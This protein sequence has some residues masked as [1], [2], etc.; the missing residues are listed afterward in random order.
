MTRI[1]IVE[2]EP[3]ILRIVAVV[4]RAMGCEPLTAKDAETAEELLLGSTPDMIITD[5]RLP[6]KDGVQLTERVKSDVSMA[7]TPVLLMSAYGEP[8]YHMADSFL[9]KPFDIDQL[10]AAVAESIGGKHGKYRA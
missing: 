7:G 6:G 10:E 2:D 9:A 4:I 3:S 1:L 5:V 8:K